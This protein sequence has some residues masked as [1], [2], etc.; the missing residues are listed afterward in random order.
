[1]GPLLPASTRGE[2]PRLHFLLVF[3]GPKRV[4]QDLAAMHQRGLWVAI[5]SRQ[6]V[7]VQRARGGLHGTARLRSGD[8]VRVSFGHLPHSGGS[9]RKSVL[10]RIGRIPMIIS[11][12][13]F[14]K[15]GARGL[16]KRG[17]VPCP[18]YECYGAARR[19][20]SYWSTVSNAVVTEATLHEHG[21]GSHSVIERSQID[22][23]LP[24]ISYIREAA[25]DLIGDHPANEP[26]VPQPRRSRCPTR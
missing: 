14:L 4:L 26:T 12:D 16:P 9:R 5:G 1:M 24:P 8:V 25:E 13:K 19:R 17:V 15:G 2:N 20:C 10:R 3:P 22:H 6:V 21:T 11:G 18:S 23:G 7:D